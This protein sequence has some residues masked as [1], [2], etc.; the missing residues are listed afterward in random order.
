MIM[1]K[2]VLTVL[3]L[4]F[5]FGTA[6]AYQ[7]TISAPESVSVGK[8]LIVTGTTTFG[9]GTPIDVVLYHQVTTS[10]EVKRTIAYVQTDKTFRV[11]FDTT[12]LTK[13]TYK[14]EVPVN[15]LG[16]SVTMRLVQLIDRSD[17]IELTSRQGQQFTGTLKLTG[18]MKGNQDSGIQV[19][20]TGPDGER[21]LGPQYI[22]TNLQGY[23][24]V[25]VP[26]EKT[27][28]YDVSFTDSKG[29]I[30]TKNVSVI[31]GEP[32]PVATGTGTITTMGEVLSA[33]ARSSRDNPAYFE[34][35][36][37]SYRMN[38]YTSSTIDWMVEYVDDR[39]ALHT[40]LSRDQ[41]NPE[42]INV[43]GR[44]KIIYFKIYPFKYSDNSIVFLYAE[45]AQSV[46]VSPTV[47]SVFA[48]VTPPTPAETQKT[49]LV[50][51]LGVA[52]A[53]MAMVLIGGRRKK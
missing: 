7:I 40:V 16:D 47:P 2:F 32:I 21:V 53:G 11:V 24:S 14:V 25:D 30:G 43:E 45:N 26:I 15:G 41:A 4:L 34:V 31:A 46:K 6:S 27:G 20:V 50:P 39:G 22:Y 17:E 52:A 35:K 38:V 23:F 51:V 1:N 29:F 5:L 49:P 33:Y 13:G 36:T 12:N 19:E 28:M 37:G 18:I 48:T 9:I 10:T 8:P 42:E 44:G 3:G